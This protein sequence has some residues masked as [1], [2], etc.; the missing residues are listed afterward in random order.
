MSYECCSHYKTLARAASDGP[1]IQIEDWYAKTWL[2]QGVDLDTRLGYIGYKLK[3]EGVIVKKAE[4]RKEKMI[5][6]S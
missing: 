2:V 4:A 3:S 1:R 6:D 5:V